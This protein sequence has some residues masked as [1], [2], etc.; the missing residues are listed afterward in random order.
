MQGSLNPSGL[1]ATVISCGGGGGGGG[2]GESI[3]AVDWM[4][5]GSECATPR[6]KLPGCRG[7]CGEGEGRGGEGRG[8]VGWS[9]QAV[10]GR[11]NRFETTT[12]SV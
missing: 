9:F 2:G 6:T 12:G 5:K 8:G 3:K 7:S 1:V 10:E 4:R 11:G